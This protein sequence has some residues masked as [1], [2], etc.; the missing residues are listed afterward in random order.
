MNT[1]EDI[2][3]G[4]RKLGITKGDTLFLRVSYKAIGET[5][6]GPDTVIDALQEVVGEEGTIMAT[7]FP[8]RQLA[9]GFR[10]KIIYEPGEDITT[11]VI[12]VL[13][14]KR[15]GACFSSN[16]ISPFVCVGKNAKILTDYHT[17]DKHNI[18]LI[19]KAI[20]ICSPK[21]LRIG[22][23][24]LDG[25]THIAFSE[26]LV[27]NHQY[28]YRIP[29]GIYYR[30]IDGKLRF[31]Y[32][33]MSQFCPKAF[34]KFYEQ[35]ILTDPSAVLGEGLVGQGKAVLTDMGRTLEIERE[36]ISPNPQILL[37]DNPQCIHCRSSYT[38]SEFSSIQYVFKLMKM[39]LSGEYT[40]KHL[41]RDIKDIF[42]LFFFG[43]KCQ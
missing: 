42:L 7:A 28:N 22:G 3:S 14:S 12:P 37:C 16:P 8:N 23:S 31:Q 40:G 9:F 4:L 32:Q 27:K 1:K 19:T 26:G 30:D 2:I 35:Y 39:K 13:L 18:G 20:E 10:K 5:E 11:G 34:G 15:K 24:A 41:V 21:C 43:R 29:E 33:N 17:P 38:Y 6:G 36:R 25:T